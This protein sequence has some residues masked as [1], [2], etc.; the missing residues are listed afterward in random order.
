[1]AAWQ[2]FYEAKHL[3]AQ[4]GRIRFGILAEALFSLRG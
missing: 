2:N 4:I 3:E 1:M